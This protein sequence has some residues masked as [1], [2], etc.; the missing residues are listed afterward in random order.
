MAAAALAPHALRLAGGGGFLRAAG[1]FLRGPGGYALAGVPIAVDALGQ[2]GQNP[3]DPAGNVAASA[4]SIGG[5]LGGGALGAILGAPLGPAGKLIGF[6][7]GSMLGSQGGGELARNAS[8]AVQG[9]FNDPIAKGIRDTERMY[10][11]QTGMMAD[12][13]RQMMPVEEAMMRLN[14][15]DQA[16]RAALASRLQGQ[17]AYQQSLLQGAMA[18][19]GAYQDPNYMAMLGNISMQGLR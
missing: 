11:S 5:G 9:Y 17:A 1:S 15:E 16:R 10:E 8:T 2:L 13:A 6:G 4:G 7:V 3:V 14:Y 19:V 18:P 12:R